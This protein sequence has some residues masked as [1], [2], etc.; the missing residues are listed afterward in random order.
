MWQPTLTKS[1]T[2]FLICRI[3][4]LDSSLHGAKIH[5][6]QISIAACFNFN[7]HQLLTSQN[8]PREQQSFDVLRVHCT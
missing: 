6:L 3:S 5:F 2:R 1:V 4:E 8:G 7:L